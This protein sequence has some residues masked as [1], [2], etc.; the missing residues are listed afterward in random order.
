V[1]NPSLDAFVNWSKGR[2]IDEALASV[3]TVLGQNPMWRQVSEFNGDEIIAEL[4]Q[5]ILEITG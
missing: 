1:E 2:S 4:K 5:K 3:R